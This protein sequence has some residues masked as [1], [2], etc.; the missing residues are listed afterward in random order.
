MQR[1]ITHI[2]DDKGLNLLHHVVLKGEDGKTKF[3]IE[4]AKANNMFDNSKEIKEWINAKTQGE[5][6]TPLHY[7]SF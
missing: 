6:W 4:F 3:L 5:G 2:V 7:A 1:S